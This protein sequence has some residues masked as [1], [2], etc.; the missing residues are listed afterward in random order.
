MKH[1]GT[2]ADDIGRMAVTV[3]EDPMSLGHSNGS[4]VTTILCLEGSLLV[5]SDSVVPH[6]P[7]PRACPPPRR[8]LAAPILYLTTLVIVTPRVVPAPLGP[9][10]PISAT[11]LFVEF[12]NARMQDRLRQATANWGFRVAVPAHVSD[13][14]GIFMEKQ[15]MLCFAG[16]PAGS[17][18]R[19]WGRAMGATSS[20]KLASR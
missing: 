3:T 1:Q 2:A 16:L 14:H 10:A 17:I 6:L 9:W 20:G 12:A 18:C 7:L 15:V 13:M 8:P 5:A 4:R 11:L 19:T